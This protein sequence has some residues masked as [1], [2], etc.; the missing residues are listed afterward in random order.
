MS[1]WLPVAGIVVGGILGVTVSKAFARHRRDITALQSR[2]SSIEN[3]HN[4]QSLRVA[5]CESTVRTIVQQ[6][7]SNEQ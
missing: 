5:E 1:E 6:G 4:M 7:A 2:M 3:R